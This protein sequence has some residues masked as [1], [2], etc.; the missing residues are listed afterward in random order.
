IGIYL[1]VKQLKPIS[2]INKLMELGMSDFPRRICIPTGTRAEYGLLSL[3][4]KEIAQSSQLQL[5]IV[6]TG[7]HLSPEFG[8]TY[9]E[10]EDD[11]FAIDR[12]IEILLSSDSAVGVTK[13]I[14]LAV[15]SFAEVFADLKPDL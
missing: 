4:L 12:K 11:G 2:L 14:G 7:M 8:L 5:Q 15:I 1:G 3:L 10:I 13:A 6:A 9:K